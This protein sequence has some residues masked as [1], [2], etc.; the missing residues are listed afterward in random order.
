MTT[1]NNPLV[2]VLMPAYNRE[3]YIEEAIEA[4]LTSTFTDFE[5]IIVD[6]H[7]TDNTL[8]IA[9]R[10]AAS[11]GRIRVYRNEKN[12]EQFPSR[13]K[14]ASMARGTIIFCADSDDTIEPD[15]LEY[16]VK[17]FNA[18]PGVNFATMYLSND[19]KEPTLLDSKSAV[20]KN[21]FENNFLLI[22]PA[23]TIIKKDFFDAIGGF[24]EDYGPS[25]D[26]YYNVKAASN[27]DVL[28]LP[29]VFF[30][31]RRHEGQEINK[32]YSY[33]YNDYRYFKEL[34][35]LPELPL[36]NEEKNRLL[37]KTK[38]DF[39]FHCLMYIKTTGEIRQTLKAF[40]L[41]GIGWKDILSGILNKPL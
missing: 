22:G 11:D 2:S 31:Y 13:N 8:E 19:I 7:S 16:V 38:R 26:M 40:K 41:A 14:A 35:K 25:G 17:Q 1:V 20:R 6:D 32:K 27:S 23:G 33:L 34:M 21:Y 12:L 10:Y 15:A 3:K 28:L 36:T 37:T 5:L 30:K 18:H 29:Y 24:P 9:H 4:V 39:L